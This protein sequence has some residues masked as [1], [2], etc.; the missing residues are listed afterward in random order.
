[1]RGFVLGSALQEPREAPAASG[2]LIQDSEEGWTVGQMVRR[3]TDGGDQS[4]L[5]G[6]AAGEVLV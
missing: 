4:Q 5:R 3:T 6:K 2:D 1:M